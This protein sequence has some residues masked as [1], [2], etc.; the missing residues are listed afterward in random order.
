MN[1][2]DNLNK[3]DKTLGLKKK[4]KECMKVNF[5]PFITLHYIGT[6]VGNQREKVSIVSRASEFHNDSH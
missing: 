5:S 3:K 1:S 4:R 2:A 6:L